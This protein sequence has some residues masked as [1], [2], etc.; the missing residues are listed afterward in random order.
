MQLLSLLQLQFC[1]CKLC[2]SSLQCSRFF[3]LPL[4]KYLYVSKKLVVVFTFG[5]VQNKLLL[6]FKCFI[7][8]VDSSAVFCQQCFDT[9]VQLGFED[10]FQNRLAVFRFSDQK[11]SEFSLGQQNYL[12]ELFRFKPDKFCNFFV[13]SSL[14]AASGSLLPSVRILKRAAAAGTFRVPS[15]RCFFNSC[16]GALST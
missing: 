3:L 9:P 16:S 1:C 2:G 10:R 4:Q 7:I 8:V 6:L 13:T 14:F 11:P 12:T 5:A 15:P